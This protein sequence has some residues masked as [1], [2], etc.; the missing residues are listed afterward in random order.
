LSITRVSFLSLDSELQRLS[1][2]PVRV[3]HDGTLVSPQGGRPIPPPLTSILALRAQTQSTR[4]HRVGETPELRSPGRFFLEDLGRRAMGEGGSFAW[5]RM[6][7]V[8][9]FGRG[10]VF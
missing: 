7:G 5:R 9:V 3:C 6:F 1:S 2:L 4:C 8:A 10:M